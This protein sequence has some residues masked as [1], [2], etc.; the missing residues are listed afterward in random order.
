[1]S[2]RI[3]SHV[4]A[5]PCHTLWSIHLPESFLSSSPYFCMKTGSESPVSFPGY[6]TAR[7]CE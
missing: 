1:M 5:L 7:T 6:I 4:W 3:L 2:Q